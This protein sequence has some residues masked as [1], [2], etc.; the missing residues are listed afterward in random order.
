MKT[1]LLFLATLI[2]FCNSKHFSQWQPF[3][4]PQ[5]S[6]NDMLILTIGDILLAANEG[7]Y[8]SSDLGTSWSIFS[9]PY[10]VKLIKKDL[11]GRVYCA[12]NRLFSSTDAGN[13]WTLN[14]DPSPLGNPSTI[15]EFFINEEGHLLVMTGLNSHTSVYKSTD[16]S[17]TW[18]MIFFG[19]T[20]APDYSK[21]FGITQ[22]SS[23]SIFIS[24]HK[25]TTG[26]QNPYLR[27][28][29]V[30]SNWLTL[31]HNMVFLNI[32]FL[33]SVM[34]LPTTA[35][36]W[37]GGY[38]IFKSY[39][40]GNTLIPINE[41]LTNL[42][43]LQLVVTP[44]VLIALTGDGIYRSLDHG[45]FW[46]RLDHTG[47]NQTIN[48]IYYDKTGALYACTVNGLFVFTGELPVELI[49]FTGLLKDGIVELSWVTAS[50]LNNLG[51]EI[52]RKATNDYWI[53][54]G[55]KSGGGTKTIVSE[56]YFSDDV[57][58]LN[59]SEVSYRLKQIDFNGVL[60]Y[61]DEINITLIPGNFLLFQNYP[62][63]FNPLTIIRYQL[64]IESKVIIKIYDILGNEISEIV[65]EVQSS[66]YK[67]KELNASGLASGVYVYKI[68]V[69]P[70]NDSQNVFLYSRKMMMVK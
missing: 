50:E 45:N 29:D 6:I 66:G 25:R 51:F 59:F 47:L 46:L 63:P 70:I 4:S 33:D 57:S 32:H 10:P 23:S 19:G 40:Y 43:I 20:L 34:F 37:Y 62:N 60:S 26:F 53:P 3:N 58:A 1:T 30:N 28:K 41:G 69:I 11:E 56:Y 64:P 55:F 35:H 5:I 12:A 31:E 65:N 21:G 15:Q 7:V 2:C 68:T 14:Y 38:G 17:F 22:N 67:E 49:S 42:N 16:F 8:R 48:R 52:Q 24:Y 13:S 36:Y 54:I 18:E 9:L 27:R 61:S 44:E 39:D